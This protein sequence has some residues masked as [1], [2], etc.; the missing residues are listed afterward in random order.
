MM[1]IRAKTPGPM[2]MNESSTGNGSEKM[3]WE[4]RPE[5]MLVQKR[6]LGSNQVS[7]APTPTIRVRAKYGALIHEIHISSQAAFG[8]LKK[9]L[10]LETKLHTQDQKLLFKD[11]ERDSNAYLDMAGVKGKSNIVL[12]KDPTSQER[13]YI[14]MRKNEKMER[15]S[16]SIAKIN[17]EVDKLAA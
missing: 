6:C 3:D 4:L 12:I 9:F 15:A 1:R 10:A 16:K 5:G 8:E 13:R 7:S 11:K 2:T 17:L 14:E